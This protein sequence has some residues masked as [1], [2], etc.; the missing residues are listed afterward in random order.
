M[1]KFLKTEYEWTNNELSKIISNKNKFTAEIISYRINLA[2]TTII[3]IDENLAKQKISRFKTIS[4][5]ILKIFTFGKIDKNKI[6][7]EK[8]RLFN[9]MKEALH[10]K[11]KI[12]EELYIKKENIDVNKINNENLKIALNSTKSHLPQM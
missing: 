5:W 7:K 6:I 4:Y 11:N 1:N 3:D 9:N 2:Q 8:M 10:K 12:I